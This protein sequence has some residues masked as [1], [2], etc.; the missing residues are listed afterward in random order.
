MQ[1]QSAVQDKTIAKKKRQVA[2]PTFAMYIQEVF[3]KTHPELKVSN[4]TIVATNHMLNHVLSNL[5]VNSDKLAK[6]S[7]KS[8]MSANHVKGA[9]K[10]FLPHNLSIRAIVR[11]EDAGKK[12]KPES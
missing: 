2:Q 12:F 4:D 6:I 11:A 10:L 7:K 1:E 5:V 9:A 3:K 8:T